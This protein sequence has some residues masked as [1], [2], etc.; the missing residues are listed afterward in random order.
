MNKPTVPTL[1]LVE[2]VRLENIDPLPE[3]G[4]SNSCAAPPFAVD[5]GITAPFVGPKG[6]QEPP[7]SLCSALLWLLSGLASAFHLCLIPIKSFPAGS[8]EAPL[9]WRWDRGSVGGGNGARWGRGRAGGWVA[10]PAWMKAGRPEGRAREV[11]L[12]WGGAAL[13]KAV[14]Y[15]PHWA[16]IPGGL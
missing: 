1:S 11:Q 7:A 13:S 16:V 15:D 2:T 8:R 6:I 9:H 5:W 10:G 14:G 12:D 3:A 4:V